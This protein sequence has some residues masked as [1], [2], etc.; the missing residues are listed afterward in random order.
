[1]SAY[2]P[3]KNVGG[4]FNSDLFWTADG[5]KANFPTLQGTLTC[6]N[7]IKF[8]DGSFQNSASSGG[9]GTALT[10][11]DTQSNSVSNVST[12]SFTN[13]TVSGSNG[14]VSVTTGTSSS[15]GITVDN[16]TTTGAGIDTLNV[17]ALGTFLSVGG[18]AVDFLSH[19]ALHATNVT[20]TVS[21]STLLT[22]CQLFVDPMNTTNVNSATITN[23]G[24]ITPY[25]GTYENDAHL[26]TDSFSKLRHL[27]DNF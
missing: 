25:V 15:T 4:E 19:K 2:P 5:D 16:G 20:Y 8:G 13:G 1:M 22:G 9:G 10:V 23:S 26:K 24:S 7:G 21:P 6:P 12:I 14:V 17:D 18:N 27:K 11:E 3:P